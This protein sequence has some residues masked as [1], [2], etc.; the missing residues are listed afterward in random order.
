LK[1][2]LKDEAIGCE[3][4]PERHLRINLTRAQWQLLQTWVGGG[5]EK[6]PKRVEFIEIFA[7]N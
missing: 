7:Y 1:D 5:N 2:K 6:L 3:N 4:I